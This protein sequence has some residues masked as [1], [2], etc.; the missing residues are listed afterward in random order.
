MALLLPQLSAEHLGLS[1]LEGEQLFQKHLSDL[2]VRVP[3][4][5]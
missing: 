2:G 1:V 4:S 3:L 5:H